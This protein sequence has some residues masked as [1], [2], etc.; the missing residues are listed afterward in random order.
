MSKLLECKAGELKQ[1][2]E[3]QPLVKVSL[4]AIQSASKCAASREVL[5]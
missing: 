1:L 5:H 3:F 4:A 2:R